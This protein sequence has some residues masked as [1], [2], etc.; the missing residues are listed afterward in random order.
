VDRD[1]GADATCREQVTQLRSLGLGELEGAH[2]LHPVERLALSGPML[3]VPPGHDG[4]ALIEKAHDTCVVYDVAEEPAGSPRLIAQVG[5]QSTE[6]RHT[7]VVIL[8]LV[9]RRSR[10]LPTR[11]LTGQHPCGSRVIEGRVEERSQRLIALA[12]LDAREGREEPTR[13]IQSKRS[14]R[15]VSRRLPLTSVEI[16]GGA[17][18]R[19]GNVVAAFVRQPVAAGQC[20]GEAPRLVQRQGQ[21]LE[22]ACTGASHG[23]S[24][25]VSC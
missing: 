17:V 25:T 3:F 11:L 24:S 12:E 18:P 19:G 7:R 15:G 23:R 20:F 9:A 10:L 8:G 13:G 6:Q 5:M 16:D 21:I 22:S 1:P 2:P 14:L 4:G